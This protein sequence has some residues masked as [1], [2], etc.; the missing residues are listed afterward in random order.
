MAVKA[1]VLYN[2]PTDPEHFV[3]YY[4]STHAPL[5]DKMP[6]LKAFEYGRSL[7]NPDGSEADIWFIATLTF[8]SPEAMG[9]AMASPEGA[10]T[11]ADVANF[12]SGGMNFVVTE[13]Q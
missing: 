5:V 11:V 6:G 12:A 7:P 3:E 4:R 9:A 2:K 8:D 10:A 13:I 1:F